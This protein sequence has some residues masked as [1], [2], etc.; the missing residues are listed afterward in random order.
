[1]LEALPLRMRLV[2]R[3]RV[4]RA[5]SGLSLSSS[6][7]ESGSKLSLCMRMTQ[8]MK[9]RHPLRRLSPYL[10][11]PAAGRQPLWGPVGDASSVI[12]DCQAED[13]ASVRCSNL[14]ATGAI[15]TARQWPKRDVSGAWAC[16]SDGLQAV[17]YVS[18]R[19]NICL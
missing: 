4:R 19:S 18:R 3:G 5:T 9:L 1:M 7:T 11:R 6:S 10:H 17:A 12:E 14:A 8:S 16:F 13:N 15:S 2:A